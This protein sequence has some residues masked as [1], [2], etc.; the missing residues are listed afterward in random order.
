MTHRSRHPAIFKVVGIQLLA[1]SLIAAPAL[2]SPAQALQL[3]EGVS[4]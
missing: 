1:L 3:C 4:D 2:V